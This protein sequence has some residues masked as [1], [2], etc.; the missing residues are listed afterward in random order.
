MA[1][2]TITAGSVVAQGDAVVQHG[3]KA[4]ATITAGKVLYLDSTTGKYK[5]ARGTTTA[6]TAVNA[7]V[8]LAL[9]GSA[10]TQPLSILT[11]GKVAIG[12]AVVPGTMYVVSL[13]SG[14]IAPLATIANGRVVAVGFATTTSV[15]DVDFNNTGVTKAT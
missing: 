3:V 6:A 7:A 5:L 11:K 8:G 14:G 10:D 1:D 9:N 2:L 13:T 12:A 15:I 4:G